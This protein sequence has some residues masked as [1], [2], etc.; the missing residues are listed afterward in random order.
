MN[1]P[2]ALFST[3]S[4]ED[5]TGLPLRLAQRAFAALIE[6]A[7]DASVNPADLHLVRLRNAARR[8]LSAMSADEQA[9][10][11]RWLALQLA[12]T[13]MQGTGQSQQRIARVDPALSASVDNALGA[14]REALLATSSRASAAA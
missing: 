11:A 5:S 8:T 2:V 4:R 9:R 10:L 1:P 12:T 14:A 7:A 6:R 3:E 13:S